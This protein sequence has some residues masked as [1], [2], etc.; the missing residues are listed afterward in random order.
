LVR[1]QVLYPAELQPPNASIIAGAEHLAKT[2]Y[3]FVIA[4]TT[5]AR[6]KAQSRSIEEGFELMSSHRRHQQITL[7]APKEKGPDLA[8][9]PVVFSGAAGRNRT[10]DPL[11]RSQV[12]YPAELQPP[13]AR[14]IAATFYFWKT[15]IISRQQ[16]PLVD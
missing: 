9:W 16:S 6:K 3:S 5:G 11:V 13:E 14:I 4:D 7:T 1:S 10:H 2:D 8:I 15:Q 12:L